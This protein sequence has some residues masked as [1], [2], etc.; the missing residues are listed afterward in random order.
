[1]IEITDAW[2]S[3]SK[4]MGLADSICRYRCCLNIFQMFRTFRISCLFPKLFMETYQYLLF[5][6]PSVQCFWR[7][8]NPWLLLYILLLP[9][10]SL[11]GSFLINIPLSCSFWLVSLLKFQNNLA[12]RYEFFFFLLLTYSSITQDTEIPQ[13]RMPYALNRKLHHGFRT[14]CTS[15]GAFHP[16]IMSCLPKSFVLICCFS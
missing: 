4:P 11:E 9:F 7:H 3:E 13:N 5:I 6:D 8:K 12:F 14:F 15:E 1:M 10:V 2:S 16:N